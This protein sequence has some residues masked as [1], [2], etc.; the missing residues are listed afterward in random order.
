[1]SGAAAIFDDDREGIIAASRSSACTG[2]TGTLVLFGVGVFRVHDRVQGP[3]RKS[4]TRTDRACGGRTW[5][6]AVLVL[7]HFTIGL[8]TSH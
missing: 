5:N 2:F 8:K 3:A 7:A 4:T 6:A 1:M